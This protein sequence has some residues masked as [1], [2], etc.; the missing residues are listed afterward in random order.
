[1]TPA[2][3]ELARRRVPLQPGQVLML[4][5]EQTR[6]GALIVILAAEVSRADG[7]TGATDALT[8][9]VA[10]LRAVADAVNSLA[11]ELGMAPRAA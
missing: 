7:T 4:R 11:G 5:A 1:M 6:R 8:M 10:A 9:P 3:C 2:R